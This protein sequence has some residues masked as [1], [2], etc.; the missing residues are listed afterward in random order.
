MITKTLQDRVAYRVLRLNY[1]YTPAFARALLPFTTV[2]LGPVEARQGD[3]SEAKL[4]EDGQDTW[5]APVI[6]I[7]KIFHGD[8]QW[9]YSF[10]ETPEFVAAATNLEMTGGV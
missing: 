6:P 7:Y 10:L 1:G 4:S 9:L 5:E 8:A 2:V 3:F